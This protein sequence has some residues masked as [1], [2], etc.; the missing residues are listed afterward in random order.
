MD[1]NKRRG[2][3]GQIHF[4]DE[5]LYR[6]R[7]AIERTNAWMDGF[8]SILSRFDTTISSWKGFNFLAFIVIAI[9]K[10]INNKKV[11]MTSL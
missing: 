10:F 9:K 6:E 11:K 1:Y 7:Y 2:E 3:E 5:K 4:L 8:R